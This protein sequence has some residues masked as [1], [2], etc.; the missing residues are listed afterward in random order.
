LQVSRAKYAVGVRQSMTDKYCVV[1]CLRAEERRHEVQGSQ[2][3]SV[4]I[5]RKMCFLGVVSS[6]TVTSTPVSA[7]R[8][9]TIPLSQNQDDLTQTNACS[10]WVVSCESDMTKLSQMYPQYFLL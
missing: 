2:L 10:L 9:L 5:E 6:Y 8:E 4:R 7:K 1:N 3:K